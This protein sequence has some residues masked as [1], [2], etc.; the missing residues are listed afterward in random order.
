MVAGSDQRVKAAVPIY[1]CGY[2][3]DRRRQRFGFPELTP[4]QALFQRAMSSEAHAPYIRC[5]VLFLDA[6][7]DFH[8]WMDSAYDTLGALS[9]IHRQAFTPRHN[10]HIAPPQGADLPA[11]MDLH[12]KGEGALPESPRLSISL[13]DDGV[14]RGQVEWAGEQV[15][16]VGIFYALGDKPPPSRFWRRVETKNNTAELPV[17]DTWDEL[18]AFANVEYASGWSLSTNLA[19]VVPA[20]LG[21]ARANL[22]AGQGVPR[23]MSAE[24]WYYA[25][26]ATDPLSPKQFVIFSLDSEHPS[27]RVNPALFGDTI[28]VHLA[29]HL[30]GDPQFRR[31]AAPALVLECAGSTDDAG[32]TISVTEHDWTPLAQTCSI[33][34]P[35]EQIPREWN[36]LE[37]PREQ[38]KTAEGKPLASWRYVDKLQLQCKSPRSAQLE[39]GAFHF[40]S[41]D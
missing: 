23:R 17:V 14:C 3:F 5:P 32:L 40:T 31:D 1:G 33:H 26:A 29:S 37:L 38:L 28:N 19:H 16:S 21:Q 22:S 7:N 13:G 41:E 36:S 24:S 2:N 4:D 18:R 6:T 12:L 27:A 9:T 35:P 34:F 15:Q 20:Q 10:H 8:G 25:T 30:V 11:W 39:V